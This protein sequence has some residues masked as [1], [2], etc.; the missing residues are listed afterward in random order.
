MIAEALLELQKDGLESV[1]AIHL[2]KSLPVICNRSVGWLNKAYN[3]V[4]DPTFVKKVCMLWLVLIAT[5][6]I[7]LFF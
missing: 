5:W 2:T 6:L 1:S 7:S 4:N 3:A